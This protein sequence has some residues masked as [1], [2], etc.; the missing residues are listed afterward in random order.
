M[1]GNLTT[2]I[3][4][5]FFASLATAIIVHFYAGFVFLEG[6]LIA[7]VMFA[8]LFILKGVIALFTFSDS[9]EEGAESE[10]EHEVEID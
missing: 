8:A 1:S 9:T 5:W 4:V 3:I 6:F 7:A 10:T 2:N